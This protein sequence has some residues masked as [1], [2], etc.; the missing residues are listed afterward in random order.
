MAAVKK[1]TINEMQA[2]AK[3]RDGMCLSKKYIN[4]RTKLKWQCAK[5]HKWEAT[6]DSVKRGSWCQKCANSNINNRMRKSIKE[7]QSIAKSRGGKCL[8]EKY[9]QV[10]KKLEWQCSEKH[11]WE[12]TPNSIINGTSWCPVC[13]GNLKL[14]LD[15]A[16]DIARNR[17][18]KCLSKQYVNTSTKLKWECA[19]GHNWKASLGNVKRG[20][21][22]SSC[23]SGISERICRE[24]F[25]QIFM[26]PFPKARPS[27][28]VNNRGY[29]MELDGFCKK[30]RIAFEHQGEQHYTTKTHFITSKDELKIRKSDDLEKV[31]LCKANKIRLF[32][33][34]ELFSRT[35]IEDLQQLIFKQCKSL[36][37]RRPASLL[38]KKVSLKRAWSFDA[39]KAV[40]KEMQAIAKSHKGKCLSK[41]FL[42]SAKK[43]KWECSEGHTWEA[44]SGSVRSGTWCLICSNKQS[45]L[46]RSLGINK[47]KQI[48]KSR[49]GKCWSR[50]YLNAH[51]KLEFECKQGHKWKAASM[52]IIQGSWCPKC[53]GKNKTI[54]DMRIAAELKGGKCLSNEYLGVNRKL[55]WQC[56]EGHKWESTP[57]SIINA[58]SWCPKCSIKIRADKI[59]LSIA[60]MNAIAKKKGGKCLSKKYVDGKTLLLWECSVGHKWKAR[61]DKIKNAGHWCHECAGIKKLSIK[62]MQ[63]LAKTHGG[64][65]LSKQ[66]INARTK[67]KWECKRGHTWIASGTSVRNNNTWCASC[68]GLKKLTIEQM[69]ELAKS[70]GG[71][72]LS[73]Q[74]V[75]TDTK[76]QWE[77]SNGHRW[78]ST[79]YHVKNRKQWCTQC[80]KKSFD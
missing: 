44:P 69:K 46:T 52:G 68:K 80:R 25:E 4:A 21:W 66:Y 3:S 48:A 79:P 1:L 19:N 11:R 22:C 70:R 14:G 55:R 2:I 41:G 32:V 50:A 38:N 75:N 26:K 43:L 7:M 77:C 42:H 31:S 24:Y 40:Y 56:A 27:W 6:P 71:R 78:M 60:E 39:N 20:G 49:G 16:N 12:A 33:V 51:E 57:G 76:L 10:H 53:A 37:V 61:P 15:V 62:D 5:G 28:L 45:G 72:C 47:I 65:C 23:S 54:T 34:P 36:H 30:L 64:K 59:K 35:E 18:G 73:K 74:Y 9:V 67:L 29:R 13:A 58:S 17:G 63:K 8:S